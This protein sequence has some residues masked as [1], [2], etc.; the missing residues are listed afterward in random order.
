MAVKTTSADKDSK[1]ARDTVRQQLNTLI[2]DLYYFLLN[3]I[4][5]TTI[6]TLPLCAIATVTS[7]LKTTNATVTQ[8]N[9]VAN[10]VAA[11]D[12]AWILGAGLTAANLATG[13]F[14]RYLLLVDANDV[15]TVQPS[16]DAATAAGCTW[17]GRPAAG[18]AIC[19]IATI[20]NAS[21][22]DFVPAVTLLGAAGI[23]TTVIDGYDDSVIM[24]SQVTP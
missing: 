12:N 23:T 24:A 13:L 8:H 17:A 11:T 1:P 4:M 3:G 22:V 2:A 19:G 5:S 18:L 7:K 20:Q 9:G 16:F 15:F 21:G 14:R 10:A 6:A